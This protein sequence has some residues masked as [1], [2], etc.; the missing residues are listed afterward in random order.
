[1]NRDTF[2]LRRNRQS[3][4]HRT[5]LRGS[6]SQTLEIKATLHERTWFVSPEHVDRHPAVPGHSRYMYSTLIRADAGN[7]CSRCVR[8]HTSATSDTGETGKH[9]PPT[10]LSRVMMM[11]FH[12]QQPHC[13]LDNWVENDRPM[14]LCGNDLMQVAAAWPRL[15]VAPVSAIHRTPHIPGIRRL[16]R[17][18]LVCATPLST[19]LCFSSNTSISSTNRSPSPSPSLQRICSTCHTVSRRS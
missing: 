14:K 6:V 11:G 12:I 19:S 1:M 3:G 18:C 17:G 5:S 10:P 9:L 16:G 13:S 7:L 4:P 8:F 2:Q 15:V